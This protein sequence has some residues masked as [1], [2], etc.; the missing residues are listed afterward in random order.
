MN[1]INGISSVLPQTL[2]PVETVRL[3]KQVP[4][5]AIC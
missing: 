2:K 5:L 3:D 1:S 4:V